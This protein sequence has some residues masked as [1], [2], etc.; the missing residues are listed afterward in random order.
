MWREQALPACD[1]GS[2]LA[3]FL[4]ALDTGEDLAAGVPGAV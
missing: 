2:V 3:V 1:V 4:Q